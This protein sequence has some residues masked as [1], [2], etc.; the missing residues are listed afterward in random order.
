M[1]A[2]QRSGLKG[3]PA[4]QSHAT[5]AN[6]GEL[7]QPDVKASESTPTGIHPLLLGN[8]AKIQERFQS[9]APKFVS[10]Q[11]NKRPLPGRPANPQPTVQI[12]PAKPAPPA[13]PYLTAAAQ[14]ASDAGPRPK[15]RSMQRS[16]QFNRPGRYIMEA[17]HMRRDQQMN[18]LKE[19]IQN[20]ARKVGMQD[21]LLGDERILRR[22]EPPEAEWWDIPL[23]PSKDYK[24]VPDGHDAQGPLPFLHGAESPIDHLVQ[25]PIPIPAPTETIRVRPHGVML[26]KQEMKKMRK[27]RRAAEQQDKRDRIKMGL[28]PPDP[29]KVKLSNLMRVLGSEAV[30]DP[31]KVEARVRREIAARRERHEQANEDRM[32]TDEERRARR[33]YKTRVEEDKGIWA[34]V[35]C[36]RQL[37]S[38]SHKFKVRKNAQQHHLGGIVIIHPDLALVVVEGSCKALKAYKRL[39]LVRIDWTDPGRPHGMDASE[40]ETPDVDLGENTCEL[41]FEGPVRERTFGG[42][43]IRT[44]A[45]STDAKVKELLGPQLSGYW[46]VAKRSLTATQG[47]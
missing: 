21:E 47:D 22:E 6:A 4:Q 32:L 1:E 2:F 15:S 35:Y 41:V 14:A 45:V 18:A 5:G 42:G 38:P 30:S 37:V 11:A 31:T 27:Q 34:Q 33:A 13:N 29:P 7:G 16:L 39:M 43:M 17:E 19:R 26:T 10:L 3:A 24:D 40:E 28:L 20:A 23:L 25:H 44:E 12:K 36:I 8:V 9:L 46:E